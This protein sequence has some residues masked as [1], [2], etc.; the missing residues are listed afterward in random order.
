MRVYVWD[1]NPNPP[2]QNILGDLNDDDRLEVVLDD[3]NSGYIVPN[4]R[5]AAA[6]NSQYHIVANDDLIVKKGWFEVS[7]KPFED[8]KVA[9]VGPK[10]LFGFIDKNFNGQVPSD[11]NYEYA[12][13]WWLVY[14]RHIIDRY[15]WVFDEENLR[16]ATSEDSHISLLLKEHGWKV[17]MLDNLPVKHL[18]SLTKKSLNIQNWCDENKFWLRNRWKTYLETRKFPKHTILVSSKRADKKKLEEIRWKY[19][20]SRITLL[21][22]DD[23]VDEVVSTAKG[24]DYSLEI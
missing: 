2:I 3:T 1:N 18:E 8:P 4:N 11:G 24:E 13:G 6:C 23:L 22:E 21:L 12:E 5:M 17:V 19:P 10:G 9:L 14:P 7:V 15:G 20:H 16:V